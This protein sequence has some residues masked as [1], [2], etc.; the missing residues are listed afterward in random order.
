MRNKWNEYYFRFLLFDKTFWPKIW[1]DFV[2]DCL[3][4][5]CSQMESMIAL[6]IKTIKKTI[7]WHKTH[8]WLKVKRIQVW[9]HFN[10]WPKSWSLFVFQLWLNWCDFELSPDSEQF[11]HSMKNWLS[12]IC[13]E[14][15]FDCNWM[16]FKWI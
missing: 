15:M 7:V 13:F 8:I 4:K 10:Y 9:N 5:M 3:L 12:I 11:W 2:F 14:V 6:N 1:F 16:A